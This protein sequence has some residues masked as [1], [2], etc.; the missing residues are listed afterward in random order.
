MKLI[1]DDANINSIRNIYEYYPIDGVTSNPSILSKAGRNPYENL[2]EIR[3]FIGQDA[4]LHVQ[5]VSTNY[6]GMLEDADRILKELGNNTFIKVPVT[7]EGLKAIKVLSSKG[8]NVTATAI[9]T[10]MQAYLAGKAGAK[11]VAPYVNRIDN[12]GFDGIHV[13]KEINDIFKANNINCEVLAASFKNSKQ[14][15]ELA[16]YGI[17]ASTVSPD[18]IEGLLKIDAVTAAVDVFTKDFEKLCG[19]NK[20]MS[21]L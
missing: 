11:Y 13:A 16:K 6:E 5:V 8:V 2:K 18:V 7:R 4:D 1:I 14:V 3:E 15:L 17:G 9:Y 10:S 21:N 20:T 19:E 12:M